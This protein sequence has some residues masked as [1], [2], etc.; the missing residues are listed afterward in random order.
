MIK[1]NDW[2]A[3]FTSMTSAVNANP[4]LIAHGCSLGAYQAVNIALR[5][6]DRFGKVV[7]LSGRYDLTAPVGPYRDLLDGHYDDAVYFQTPSHYLPNLGDPR[8]LDPIRR[9]E[10]TLAVGEDDPVAANNAHLDRTLRAKGARSSLHLW[11]GE[12]HKPR[13]WR[14]MVGHYL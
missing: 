3:S 4:F 10:F 9:M 12:A 1:P 13:Y 7:A 8:H 5:H 2:P 6:P 14:K 11:P